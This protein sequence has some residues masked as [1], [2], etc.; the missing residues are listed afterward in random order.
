MPTIKSTFYGIN[1]ENHPK[2]TIMALEAK[3]YLGPC[4]ISMTVF[5]KNLHLRCLTK[6]F[7]K[8]AIDFV[9]VILALKKI[10]TML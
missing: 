5:F 10:K 3:G 1:V 4:Q 6:I 7:W 8:D 9:L 2:L